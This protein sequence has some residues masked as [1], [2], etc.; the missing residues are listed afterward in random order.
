MISVRKNG[1]GVA[2]NG[3]IKLVEIFIGIAHVS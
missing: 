1:F 2:I 3:L